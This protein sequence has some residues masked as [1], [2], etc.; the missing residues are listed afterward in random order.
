MAERGLFADPI[1]PEKRVECR[2]A[3]PTD[4]DCYAL[5]NSFRQLSDQLLDQRGRRFSKIRLDPET[6]MIV[7]GLEP[8]INNQDGE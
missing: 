6:R 7:V 8:N 5:A 2:V 4:K 3:V 1:P